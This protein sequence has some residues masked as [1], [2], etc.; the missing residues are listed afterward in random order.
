ME[1]MI[2]VVERVAAVVHR[3]LLV[4]RGPLEPC[5]FLVVPVAPT[6]V[7]R[8]V[9]GDKTETETVKRVRQA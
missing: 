8:G 7:V 9:R 6:R 4:L 1:E 2:L 3:A 5:L